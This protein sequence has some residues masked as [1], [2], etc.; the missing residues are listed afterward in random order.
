MTMTPHVF[1]NRLLRASRLLL[2]GVL[3]L[4][5]LAGTACS[6]DNTDEQEA[7][8][9]P[10][11]N[12]VPEKPETVASL[13]E[14]KEIEE[15]LRA[16]RDK[17]RYTD[18]T[19]RAD[20]SL[21][22]PLAAP[23]KPVVEEVKTE[24]VTEVTETVKADGSETVTETVTEVVEDKTT[25][26]A[27]PAVAAVAQEKVTETPLPAP[28]V[29]A[30]ATDETPTAAPM[31]DQVISGETTPKPAVASVYEQQLAAQNATR[32]PD[33][34]SAS[35]ASNTASTAS[36]EASA[37]AATAASSSSSSGNSLTLNPP[38]NE[39][40]RVIQN[41]AASDGSRPIETIYFAQG[42]HR[43]SA[44]DRAKLDRIARTQ[45]ATGGT[46]KIVGHASSRTRDMP[47][48]RH[49]IVNLNVSQLR[50]SKIAEYFIEAGVEP[51]NLLVES[52]SDAEPL[53]N[54]PMPSAEAKNR[55]AEIFLLN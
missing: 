42:S 45:K 44:A 5:L 20:T 47:E 33:T 31:R 8:E 36:T 1:E 50:A 46:L 51:S 22:P 14:A 55:R 26:A 23:P 38:A 34:I 12:K 30:A 25:E 2:C 16:D 29:A 18:E 49:M 21:Q 32:L 52:V 9:Y 28:E 48:A 53:I 10:N 15:G 6:T 43:I 54:E 37:P 3:L 13:A 27:A 4:G 35:G 41:Y 40:G 24:T 7:A 19:L 11:L 17:A 39:G